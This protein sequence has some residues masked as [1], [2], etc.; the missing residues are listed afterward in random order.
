[1]CLHLFLH[2]VDGEKV[3]L[4]FSPVRGV[5]IKTKSRYVMLTTDFGLS[6]RFDGNAQAGSSKL[7][8]TE[9]SRIFMHSLHIL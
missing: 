4:P 9:L 8:S 3:G 2:Q 7:A 6:V 5:N 1:M